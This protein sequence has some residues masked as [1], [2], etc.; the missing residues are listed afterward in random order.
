MTNETEISNA[1]FMTNTDMD[2]AIKEI[3]KHVKSII[4]IC[5][6]ASEQTVRDLVVKD[7]FK[8][9]TPDK[10]QRNKLLAEIMRAYKM[11][12]SGV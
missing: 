11:A 3:H 5:S 4:V 9:Y 10:K 6:N 7:L 2:N 1:G 12:N 8:T